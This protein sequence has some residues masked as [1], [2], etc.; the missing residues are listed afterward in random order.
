MFPTVVPG[1]AEYKQKSQNGM[2][3]WLIQLT[4]REPA[5]ICENDIDETPSK[6]RHVETTYVFST[7]DVTI[8]DQ[9]PR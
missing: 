4:Q 6:R 1:E 7:A 5:R 2:D 3:M 9:I 8:A